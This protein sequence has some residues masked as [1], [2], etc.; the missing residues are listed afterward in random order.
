ME[1]VGDPISLTELD[2]DL[3]GRSL[4]ASTPAA[5]TNPDLLQLPFADEIG[6]EHEEMQLLPPTL[7]VAPEE[8]RAGLFEPEKV[9]W[10]VLHPPASAAAPRPAPEPIEIVDSAEPEPPPILPLPESQPLLLL[11]AEPIALPPTPKPAIRFRCPDCNKKW[12]AVPE[13]AG[14]QGTCKCGRRLTIPG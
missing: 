11:E 7:P 10:N 3:P 13:K 2:I 4:A 5:Q 1:P 12:K 14:R 6:T 9:S 8:L